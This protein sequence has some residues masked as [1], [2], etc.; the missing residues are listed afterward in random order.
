VAIVN[1]KLSANSSIDI[2]DMQGKTVKH[3]STINPENTISIED[4]APGQYMLNLVDKSK[5][6][7]AKTF[8]VE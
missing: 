3:I 4:L 6:V 8:V 2:Y 1:Y 7:A 5:K